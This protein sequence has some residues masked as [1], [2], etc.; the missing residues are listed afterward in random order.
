MTFSSREKEQDETQAD[1][2]KKRE[3][4]GA[5]AFADAVTDASAGPLC[6]SSRR[7]FNHV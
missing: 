4:K 1:K 6:L 7:N 3:R 5:V 2:G